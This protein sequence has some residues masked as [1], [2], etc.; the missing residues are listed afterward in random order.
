MSPPV[1]QKSRGSAEERSRGK[2]W[3]LDGLKKW[4]FHLFIDAL[5][6]MLQTALLLLRCALS[7][8]LWTIS[9]TVAGVILAFTVFG[10]AS[11]VF[12]TLAAIFSHDCPYQTPFSFLFRTIT[13]HLAHSKSSFARRMRSVAALPSTLHSNSGGSLG[14][15]LRRFRPGVRILRLRSL[16]LKS[17]LRLTPGWLSS[18]VEKVPARISGIF[19]KRSATRLSSPRVLP[20]MT[21]NLRPG[22][23]M[24]L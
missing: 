10:V 3:E 20:S 13:R 14:R 15:A 8:Y 24:T 21:N 23:I 19:F 2:Q 6:V 16:A 11:H 17:F 18:Q 4:H 7:K 5:P 22:F 1:H 9:H 12:F